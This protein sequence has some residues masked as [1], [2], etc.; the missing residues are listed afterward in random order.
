MGDGGDHDGF[1]VSSQRLLK[2]P[3]QFRVTIRNV[4]LLVLSEVGEAVDDLSE[5]AE[6][7]IDLRRLLHTFLLDAGLALPLR[8]S[9]VDQVQSAY[10]EF[11]VSE[12]VDGLLLNLDAEDAMRP[13]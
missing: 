5:C 10:L 3:C 1:G 8:A 9:Q 6:G 13:R 4:G 11:R 2:N 12:A 7:K